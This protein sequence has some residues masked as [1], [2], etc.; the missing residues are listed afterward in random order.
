MATGLIN[1][2]D[3]AKMIGNDL[4]VGLLE[5]ITNVAPEFDAMFAR[6]ID[7]TTYKTAVRTGL[8][9]VGFRALNAGIDAGKSVLDQRT[10]N[11]YIFGGRVEI[12]K[13]AY[14]AGRT[15]GMTDLD[16]EVLESTGIARNAKLTIGTQIFYGTTSNQGFVGLQSAV[17][18]T[19]VVDAT[20]TTESTGSSVYAVKTGLQDVSLVFGN[21]DV[22]SLTE[23]RDETLRDSNGKPFPGRVADLFGYIGLQVPHKNCVGR[24]KNL[25]TQT[26]KTL[27]DDMLSDLYA[28]FPIGSKP[29]VFIMS[30]RS[31]RQLQKSRNSKISIIAGNGNFAATA[32]GALYT[33]DGV[34]IVVTDSIVENEAIA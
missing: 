30:R 20:G 34:P 11:C 21:G 33:A 13:A 17:D 12:D 4:A 22:M 31:A 28:K 32:P 8:P 3:R 29:D 16:V 15:V 9:D 23:F 7:G 1:A 18:S 5:E 6:V 19:M 26:D 10:V 2:T 24:L 14:T 25:T 27:T